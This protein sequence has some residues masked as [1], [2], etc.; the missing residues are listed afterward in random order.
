MSENNAK[1]VPAKASV[2]RQWRVGTFSMG[3]VLIVFG[4]VLL[5]AQFKDFSAVELVSTWWPAIMVILGLEILAAYYLSGEDKPAIKYDILSIFMVL[6]IGGITFGLYA[7]TSVGI[8][9][10]L[11]E[12][13]TSQTHTID[14]PE[15]RFPLEDGIKNIVV[16]GS[17]FDSGINSLYLQDTD[18]NQVVAFAQATVSAKS[19]EAAAALVPESLLKT[20]V[21]GDTLFLDLKPLPSGN[22]FQHP[23]YLNQTIIL[24]GNRNVRVESESG[25]PLKLKLNHIEANWAVNSPGTVEVTVVGATDLKLEAFATRL[26]GGVDWVAENNEST[27]DARISMVKTPEG[28]ITFEQTIEGGV[29]ETKGK[30][31]ITFGK[32]THKLKIDADEVIV[33]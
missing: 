26:F 27:S 9:P 12:S 17:G 19:R 5:L 16:K 15:Q 21:V 6:L 3:M 25:S 28:S 23:F 8:L 2:K 18:A 30:A 7:L 13:I 24:P 14:V 4:L 20:H 33:N 32:G 1:T 31:G 22:H 29:V 10:A 11:T